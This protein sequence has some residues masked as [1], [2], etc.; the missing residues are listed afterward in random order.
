MSCRVTDSY[1]ACGIEIAFHRLDPRTGTWV[2][3]VLTNNGWWV[4][5]PLPCVADSEVLHDIDDIHLCH[6]C[7]PEE[8][9]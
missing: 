1:S 3:P 7:M 4:C 9:P 2:H 6:E 5:P 8:K